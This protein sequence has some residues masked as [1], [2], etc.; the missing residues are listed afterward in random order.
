[1]NPDLCLREASVNVV[2]QLPATVKGL[3]VWREG[4][5]A[6]ISSDAGTAITPPVQPEVCE[7]CR[8]P[9]VGVSL[10]YTCQVMTATC[11]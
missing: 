3:R 6:S 4:G 7:R 1:M 9:H 2:L 11:T 10:Q 5:R 8:A